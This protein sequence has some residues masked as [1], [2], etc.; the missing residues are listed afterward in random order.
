MRDWREIKRSLEQGDAAAD[1]PGAP[2]ERAPENGGQEAGRM[3]IGAGE[4]RPPLPLR[5]RP[6]K[7]SLFSWSTFPRDRTR[8][9]TSGR[10]T[11]EPTD[12]RRWLDR[13]ALLRIVGASFVLAVGLILATVGRPWFPGP[14]QEPPEGAFPDRDALPDGKGAAGAL[15]PPATT[16]P[17]PSPGSEAPSPP[18]SGSAALPDRS[19][20]APIGATAG[21]GGRTEEPPRGPDGKDRTDRAP[22]GR[23]YVVRP[24][25]TLYRIAMRT[26]GTKA[27][28]AWIREAN[29]LK[30]NTIFVGQTLLLPDA[31]PMEERPKAESP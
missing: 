14:L 27:A 1:A 17:S 21:A 6:K 24:G 10:R 5:T 22:A 9:A 15:P 19:E 31:P 18:A 20:A 3:G 11:K 25:D 8:P 23:R 16:T 7:P 28:I 26:Y 30:D 2:Q 4:T 12:R 13:P 29:G